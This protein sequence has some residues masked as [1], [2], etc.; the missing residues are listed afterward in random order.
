MRLEPRCAA[1]SSL[2]TQSD[3]AL[4]AGGGPGVRRRVQPG[5]IARTRRR[6]A[7]EAGRRRGHEGLVEAQDTRRGGGRRDR[8]G[9]GG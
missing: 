8:Q 5:R 7:P 4:P 9:R 6:R 1:E 3:E 2:F